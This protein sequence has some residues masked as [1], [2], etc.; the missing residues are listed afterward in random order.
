MPQALRTKGHTPKVV[1]INGDDNMTII[2]RNLGNG[3]RVPFL[4]GTTVTLASGVQSAEILSGTKIHG[5]KISEAVVQATLLDNEAVGR[6][7]IEKDTTLNTLTLHQQNATDVVHYDVYV[8]LGDAAPDDL[9]GS[10]SSNQVW[11]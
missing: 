3:R 1:R 8:F 2:Y 10:S 9:Y 6:Y 4:L 11:D 5:Y 7:Y